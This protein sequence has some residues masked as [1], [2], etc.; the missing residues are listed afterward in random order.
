MEAWNGSSSNT[1]F[2]SGTVYDQVAKTTL[3]L[4]HNNK[5]DFDINTLRQQS[6]TFE[7]DYHTFV[8]NVLRDNNLTWDQA[9][10][11]PSDSTLN[12]D[13]D[14]IHSFFDSQDI[15]LPPVE[16]SIKSSSTQETGINPALITSVIAV[17]AAASLGAWLT[18]RRHK[19]RKNST[20]AQG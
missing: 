7:H 9:V 5:I 4:A 13:G 16:S 11:L 17:G 6:P 2:F 8:D 3:D 18:A 12:I 19:K 20:Q 14:H 1:G 15:V 10:Q